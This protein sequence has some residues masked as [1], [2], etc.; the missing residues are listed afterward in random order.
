MICRRYVVRGV[1][2]GVFFRAS[3]QRTAQRLGVTGWARNLPDGSVELVA[4]GEEQ[5]LRELERWLW[6]GPPNARVEEVLVSDA[7]MNA[8][9]GFSIV[10]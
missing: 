10:Q 1:V 6:Q 8:Y 2:Q 7:E 9:L 4:C 3:A 5:P